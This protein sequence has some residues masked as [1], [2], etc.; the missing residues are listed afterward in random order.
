VSE[1]SFAVDIDNVPMGVLRDRR[2]LRDDLDGELSY[3]RRLLHGRLDLLNFELRRRS[4]AETRSLIEALPEILADGDQPVREAMPKALSIELPEMGNRQRAIDHALDDD[5]LTDLPAIDDDELAAIEADL[6]SVEEQISA[7][8]RAVY[9]DLEVI[10][11]E[12]TRPYRD[13]LATV[14]ELPQHG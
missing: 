5:F 4:G 13:G 8:R 1:P 14:D 3:Y 7:Q 2:R 10:L 11:E 9:D 6:T 12:L